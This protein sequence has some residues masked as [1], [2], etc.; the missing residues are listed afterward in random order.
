MTIF[1][2]A[3]R[4]VSIFYGGV[5]F[6][7]LPGA[8]VNT[9][10]TYNIRI[11]DN[12]T[13]I[14]ALAIGAGGGGGGCSSVATASA[15]GAGGG[16]LSYSNAITVTPGETLTV[17]VP[18]GAAAGG[19]GGTNGSAG[20][21]ASIAR[22][23]TILLSADGGNGSAG[24]TGSTAS[25]GAA[26]GDAAVGVGDVRYSGGAGGSG[27]ASLDDGGGGGGAA[28]YAGNGGKGA[29]GRNVSG[30]NAVSGSGGGGGGA[31]SGSTNEGGYG[32]GV[33]WYGKG[34]DGVGG[35]GGTFALRY[36]TLGSSLGGRDGVYPYGVDYT[37]GRSNENVNAIPGGGGGGAFSGGTT[38]ASG[39]RGGGGAVRIL[40]GLNPDW[41]TAKDTSE[42]ILRLRSSASSSTSTISMPDVEL[43]DTAIFIDYAE[44]T[45][46]APT[47]VTPSGFTIRLNTT[48]G[49]RRLTTYYKQ[50][51][52]KS[53]TGT[54]LTGANGTSLNAKIIIV[55]AGK[56]GASFGTQGTD[57]V[58]NGLVGSSGTGASTS[59]TVDSTDTYAE[60][61]PV[62]FAFFNSTADISS[63]NSIVLNGIP[64]NTE[65][66]AGPNNNTY[67]KVGFFPQTTSTTYSTNAVFTSASATNTY[68]LWEARFY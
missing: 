54:V 46:G 53:E 33:L 2:H 65:R 11:P 47:A 49:T 7:C 66:V 51:L 15:G 45:S 13:S 63:N 40:W 55:I 56:R 67:V 19:T 35:T 18:N 22:G 12:V 5:T 28:G 50:I 1:H 23:A 59:L 64:L 25:A 16:A 41:G 10:T 8:T 42:N 60:G 57:T 6:Y 26:G 68:G 30:N 43:G 20:L 58:L 4:S 34:A 38:A 52:S 44:N 62:A 24:R 21:T 17:L 37:A 9:Q 14:A 27:S 32:G 29:S 48:T 31:T 3:L 61:I 39:V 36:G